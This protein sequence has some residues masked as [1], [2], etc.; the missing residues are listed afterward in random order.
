[1]HDF[2][3]G[4]AVHRW[5]LSLT[6]LSLLTALAAGQPPTDKQDLERL[7]GN[8]ICIGGNF[9]GRSFGEAEAVEMVI[10]FAVKGDR[11]QESEKGKL[12]AT[13]SIKLSGQKSPREID[14]VNLDPTKLSKGRGI[15]AFEGDLLKICLRE[16]LNG[17]PGKFEVREGSDDLYWILRRDQPK[18]VV[19]PRSL[20]SQL[21]GYAV[22][23]VMQAAVAKG[24][25]K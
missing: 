2:S 22:S 13:R 23:P 20:I 3:G 25:K 12:K 14:T 21:F 15:Y 5:L 19:E 8:W 10:T 7:Q 4:Q 11:L 9:A 18:T 6:A 24:L 1:L 17:R 16:N